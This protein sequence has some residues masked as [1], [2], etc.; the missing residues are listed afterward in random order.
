MTGGRPPCRS[1]RAAASSPSNV[2]SRT[3]SRS[4]SAMAA[5][6]L[7]GPRLCENGF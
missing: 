2:D 5:K 4:V 3:F 1:L 7:R 6:K